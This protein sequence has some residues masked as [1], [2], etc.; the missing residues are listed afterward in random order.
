M[1]LFKELS[2]L[3]ITAMLSIQLVTA[4]SDNNIR[5]TNIRGSMMLGP[6]QAETSPRELH[7]FH[8]QSFETITC[9]SY[10]TCDLP[11]GDG[12][13]IF[14]C[15]N[16]TRPGIESAGTV[17]MCIDPDRSVDGDACGCCTDVCPELCQ[18]HCF[19]SNGDDVDATGTR[20]GGGRPGGRGR[21]GGAGRGPGG[22]RGGPPG[23][24][25]GV[26]LQVGDEIQCVNR[27]E[28]EQLLT[29]LGRDDVSCST[30][31]LSV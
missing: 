6:P 27:I 16:I 1:Y 13:G 18:C 7:W 22:G 20:L 25:H 29:D 9:S 3:C 5:R 10:I 28:A 31:C 4:I 26:E 11:H 12:E 24:G 14:V 2:K 19:I 15:R 23:R 8:G 17:S 21:A 30:S